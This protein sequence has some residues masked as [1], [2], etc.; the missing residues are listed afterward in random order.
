MQCF[1]AFTTGSKP[2]KVPT[3]MLHTTV[4]SYTWWLLLCSWFDW[5]TGQGIWRRTWKGEKV[6]FVP[7]AHCRLWIGFSMCV[8]IVLSY[9]RRVCV[10]HCD[11][12]K[13]GAK[14]TGSR[15]RQN[16]W[17]AR[18]LQKPPLSHLKFCTQFYW[19]DH[20]NYISCRQAVLYSWRPSNLL[21]TVYWPKQWLWR[22]PRQ[23][24]RGAACPRHLDPSQSCCH[25]RMRTRW[26]PGTIPSWLLNRIIQ[27]LRSHRQAATLRWNAIR[28]V[29]FSYRV[30]DLWGY[31]VS[32]LIWACPAAN[33]RGVV[34]LE[35][36]ATSLL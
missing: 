9:I 15:S 19:A 27:P 25:R 11:W 2:T 7:T 26:D 5:C 20:Y 16:R 33:S 29:M 31:G 8:C 3:C 17:W 18:D 13:L 35:L 12:W 10:D 21:L 32:D 30:T 34:W 14:Q 1:E 28:A 22:R 24:S 4:L 23:I 6:L 36:V